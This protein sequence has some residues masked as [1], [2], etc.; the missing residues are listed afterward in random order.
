LIAMILLVVL[1]DTLSYTA[2]RLMAR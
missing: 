2:R 1:V